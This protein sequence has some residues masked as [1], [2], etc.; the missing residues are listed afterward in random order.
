ME[1]ETKNAN[2]K[3]TPPKNVENRKTRR[4]KGTPEGLA[5]KKRRKKRNTPNKVLDG[6]ELKKIKILTQPAKVTLI[7][8][9]FSALAK[10]QS[11]VKI[12]I[13]PDPT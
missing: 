12:K 2:L 10:S 4:H 7:S 1:I 13:A 8:D 11:C 9:F 5:P 6:S 3:E